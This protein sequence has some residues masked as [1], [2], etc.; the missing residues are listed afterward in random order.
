M[1]YL[2]TLTPVLQYIFWFPNAF[3]LY[4]RAFQIT[5]KTGITEVYRI[6]KCDD[7]VYRSFGRDWSLLLQI[8]RDCMMKTD[9]VGFS[10]L[11]TQP[12]NQEEKYYLQYTYVPLPADVFITNY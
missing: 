3:Q 5:K 2:P 8:I 7:V 10:Y 4:R 6:V 11:P 1:R 12:N 9:V